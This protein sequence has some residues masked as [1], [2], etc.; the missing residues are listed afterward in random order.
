MSENHSPITEEDQNKLLEALADPNF[1]GFCGCGHKHS[2]DD[3]PGIL[4]N[5]AGHRLQIEQAIRVLA[6][7]EPGSGFLTLWSQHEFREGFYKGLLIAD[8]ESPYSHATVEG[9]FGIIPRGT[10]MY[11][12]HFYDPEDDCNLVD[13]Y[14][15]L[16]PIRTF[17]EKSWHSAKTWVDERFKEAQRDLGQWVL[18]S[19]I[20]DLR[21]AGRNLGIAAHFVT[22]L[23]QPMHS[24]NFANIIGFSGGPY[25]DKNDFRHKH[26]ED[27]ADRIIN[28]SA[29]PLRPGLFCD[30]SRVEIAFENDLETL[31]MQTARCAKSVFTEKV[32]PLMLRTPRE[33][34]QIKEAHA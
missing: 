28:N 4:W 7:V 26:F 33:A 17:I 14:I 1:G 16:K 24:A 9:I 13:S 6:A 20:S 3:G 5:D 18:R 34:T 32:K 25:V 15:W 2:D 23:T 10:K 22:D 27:C 19:E 30:P 11:T 29:S 31:V 12:G 21:L 8:Y